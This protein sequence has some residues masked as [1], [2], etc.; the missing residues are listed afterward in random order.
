MQAGAGGQVDARRQ[1]TLAVVEDQQR[2]K[3]LKPHNK[4][5]D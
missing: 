4:G 1:Q 5:L 2:V 3:R